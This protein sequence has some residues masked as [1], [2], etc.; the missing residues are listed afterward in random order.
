MEAVITRPLPPGDIQAEYQGEARGQFITGNYN[1]QIGEI[2]GG[3]VNI[4]QPRD[5]PRRQARPTPVRILP[6]HLDDLLDRTTEVGRAAKS[7]SAARPLDIY[8]QSGVGKTSLL[9]LLCRHSL[10]SVFHDGVIYL[11]AAN[12]PVDDLLQAIFDAFYE[13]NAPYK[14]SQGEIRQ[15][16]QDKRALIVLDD[17]ALEREEIETLMDA[18]PQ[19]TF[20]LASADRRLWGQGDLIALS[21]LPQEH[22]VQLFER[23]VGRPLEHAE[24][25]QVL[26]LCT[27]LKGHPLH[28]V[29]AAGLVRESGLSI[30]DIAIDGSGQPAEQTLTRKVISALQE[31][32]KRVAAS[33]A[34]L[35]GAPLHRRHLRSLTGLEDPNVVVDQLLQRGV[36][37][38][39]SPKYT[40]AG[41]L[42]AA[43][44]QV[45]DLSPWRQ[46]SLE[47]FARW[48]EARRGRPARLVEESEALRSLI[49]WAAG[50]GR[51]ANVLRLAYL[52][53]GALAL[54]GRWSA[55]AWVLN[56]GLQAAQALGNQRARAWALHQLGTRALCLGE[57]A[58]A[59]GYLIQA[60]RLR[61][62]LGDRAGAAVTRHN[63][64]LILG[65]TSGPSNDGPNGS[66]GPPSMPSAGSGLA[67]GTKI[68]LYAIAA[69]TVI[70][71]GLTLWPQI[72]Q[73]LSGTSTQALIGVTSTP[74]AVLIS[75]QIPEPTETGPV[76]ISTP[77]ATPSP[78]ITLPTL[79]DPAVTAEP[80]DSLPPTTAPPRP[81][82]A[83]QP[84][85]DWPVYTVRR[86]DTLWSIAQGSGATVQ[87]LLAA[88]CL[89]NT[90]IYVNQTLFVPRLP[91]LP[92]DA[93]LTTPVVPTATDT[94]VPTT[95]IPTTLVPTTIS[96]TT[97][98][99]TTAVPT[100]AVPT[101][102]VPTTAVP[103]E[104]PDLVT[105]LR[106]GKAW[107]SKSG[108]QVPYAV[109]VT[110]QGGSPAGSFSTGVLFQL[111]NAHQNPEIKTF[112]TKA[113]LAPGGYVTFED[114]YQVPLEWQGAELALQAMADICG[115]PPCEVLES[116]EDN[117][118]AGPIR[119]TLPKNQ[120][121]EP[122]IIA[123]KTDSAYLVDSYDDSGWYAN[124][125]LQGKASDPQ[126]AKLSG[127]ALAWSATWIPYKG[128]RQELFLGT[129]T[130]LKVPLYADDCYVN[131]YTI[132][133]TAEDSLGLTAQD[134]VS[135]S[136]EG[137]CSGG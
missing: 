29:Q 100:T 25:S 115:V 94:P 38:A 87:E 109:S 7:L 99:P 44:E 67:L 27:S 41:E 92:A 119:V 132:T 82:A 118:K 13:F 69:L 107:L 39:H 106:S 32:E 76:L 34:A 72:R 95:A 113:P 28:I 24:R 131:T 62:A 85:I 84:R 78:S 110:N 51:W 75:T 59:R 93:E 40:L 9:R 105:D 79:T 12:Q 45:W 111:V 50:V 43:L 137:E 97:V 96:P 136:I 1:V 11:R 129:G 122:V 73:A 112:G 70:S 19:S 117:N 77:S 108:I 5:R 52:L 14:P 124:V 71:A 55:W 74:G 23:E 2:H 68:A 130:E 57:I 116:D 20:L 128:E 56:R 22:A 80:V 135:V 10:T 15:G 4:I 8:A 134:R 126:D 123:P 33:V 46:A 91:I 21:G 31:P 3:V 133:L 101:T 54:A 81:P 30:T 49:D 88:N 127:R 47:H 120:P 65:G 17:V 102:A 125:P 35:G 83:C 104:P 114:T 64:N 18:A 6:R 89:P 42:G 53:E 16:L 86:G 66:S 26:D 37:Q 60:L 63:L 36:L 61:E 58:S 103:T 48:A 90:N 98:V 121:P